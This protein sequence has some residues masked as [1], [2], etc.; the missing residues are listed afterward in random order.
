M[1]KWYKN[2]FKSQKLGHFWSKNKNI[3]K[4]FNNQYFT[5]FVAVFAFT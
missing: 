2:A 5:T 4:I 1:S 3:K